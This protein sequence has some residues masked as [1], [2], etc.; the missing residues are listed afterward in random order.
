MHR[1]LALIFLAA[2]G[3]HA[4]TYFLLQVLPD[5]AFISLGIEG[6]R[7]EV[8]A[9]FHA[10]HQERSYGRVLSDLV[11]LDLG[12]TLDGI[13]VAR[14]L[15]DALMTSAPRV[16]SAFAFILAVCVAAGLIP[17]RD[18]GGV[19][20]AVSSFLAFLPPYVHPFL[21]LVFV[22]SATF[23]FGLG[24]GQGFAYAVAVIALA[25]APAAMVYAQAR[26][27]TRRNLQSD[28]ART[29]LAV[30]A[31]PLYQRYRLLH[32]LAAEIVPS[33]EKVLTSLVAV[34]LFVEP[35]LGLSGFG[36]M[37]VRAVKRSDADLLL[38]VTVALAIAVGLSRLVSL[39][40]RRHYGMA[41]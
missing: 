28:F 14:E 21:G 16:A 8:L 34:L 38:A 30:G 20:E 18:K 35:I 36:T 22:L 4:L 2:L 27:I 9:A 19:S 12:R 37:A 5:A 29:L 15:A 24:V 39:L 33:L 17:Q 41:A 25:T 6:A 7:Q 10:A 1:E 3:A 32:N 26:A 31:T 40:V 13:P 23:W 11:R